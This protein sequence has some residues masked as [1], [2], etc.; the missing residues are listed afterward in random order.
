MP[1]EPEP[2]FYPDPDGSGRMRWWDG[3]KWTTR[4]LKR[5]P[6]AKLELH[7]GGRARVEA[8]DDDHHGQIGLIDAIMDDKSGIDVYIRF[9]G[10]PD[11]YAYRRDEVVAVAPATHAAPAQRTRGDSET[12]SQTIEQ[13]AADVHD[14]PP[15]LRADDASVP[16]D[17]YDDPSG[18]G[19]QR[20][21]DGE[22]W[23]A[24]RRPSPSTQEPTAL[25]EPSLTSEAQSDSPMPKKDPTKSR[26][27]GT[28]AS[29]TRSGHGGPGYWDNKPRMIESPSPHVTDQWLEAM[30]DTGPGQVERG[31][32]R[33]V[34]GVAIILVG[35][36]LFMS[37]FLEWG[38]PRSYIM[39]S[40]TRSSSTSF[41]PKSSMA[42]LASC[43]QWGRSRCTTTAVAWSGFSS[44]DNN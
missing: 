41:S 28:S 25:V 21:W 26:P 35:A 42:S 7:V 12:H 44:I 4:H 37:G 6:P 16:A 5:T 3:Q 18:S 2:G 36:A 39:S 27:V 30:K 17:W 14:E 10:D 11:I 38:R 43:S 20:W 24:R 19:G 40:P 32:S 9:D 31:S 29:S 15:V 33:W 8:A 13:L 34:A 23:T 1:T 22:R